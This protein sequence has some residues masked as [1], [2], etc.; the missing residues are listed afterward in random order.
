LERVVTPGAIPAVVQVELTKP[1]D[2]GGELLGS[3]L[4]LVEELPSAIPAGIEE[5]DGGGWGGNECSAHG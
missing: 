5:L 4:A 2:F 1:L 3:A